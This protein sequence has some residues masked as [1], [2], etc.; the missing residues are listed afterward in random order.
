MKNLPILFSSPMVRALLREIEQPGTGKTQTRRILTPQPDW[1]HEVVKTIL[2]GLVWPIG[3]YDQQCGG[4]VKLPPYSVDDRLYVREAWRAETTF[5]RWKPKDI[6][7]GN[8]IECEEDR[9]FDNARCWG[10]RR[11]GMF[12]PR[13]ASRITLTVTD[14]RVQ[15]LQEISEEDAIAEGCSPLGPEFLIPGQY[16]YSDP[17]KPR[18]A[19]SATSAYESLWNS[20]NAKRGFGWDV[21]PWV[22]AYTFKPILGNID[23]V[24]K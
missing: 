12:H 20:L 19:I 8:K 5:D 1:D 21:N 14:V 17:S 2:D 9:T 15:R 18:T 3:K 11:P 13:W 10:K 4:P 7:A 22:T 24:T 16:L 23:E 6:P